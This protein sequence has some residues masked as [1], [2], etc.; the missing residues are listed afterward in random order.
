M[1]SRA[2]AIAASLLAASAP[3]A[4]EVPEGFEGRAILALAD[5]AMVASGY[6]DGRLGPRAADRLAVIP[7]GEGPPRAS[8]VDVSNSV[9]TWPNVL[10]LTPDQR[11]AIVTEP[12]AQ[13]PE[14]ASLFEE[15][16]RGRRISVIDV[17]DPAAPRVV[18]EIDAPGTPAAVDVHPSGELVAVTLPFQGE[19]ALYPF[20]DGRL[21]TPMVQDL[22]L[23]GVDDTFVPEFKW[24]PDGRFAA[25]TLGGADRVAFFR[26][27]EGRLEPWGEPLV[28]A[29]LPGKGAWTPDGRH[30]VVT[31]ITA[32]PDMAQVAYGR[33]ATLL[34][35]F[36]FD[37]TAEPDSPPRRADDRAPDPVSAGVQHARIAQLPAGLGYVENFAISPNGRH[38]VG[39]NM[40]AS[41]LP[42]GHPGRS[43]H[44]AL[45]LFRLD[46]ETGTIAPLDTVR[47]EGTILPQGIAFD[48]AGGHLVVTS[49][50]HDDRE[51]GSLSFWRL[52]GTEGGAAGL[53]P[54]G[55]PITVPR[56]VHLVEVLR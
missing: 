24:R 8:A 23:D 27:A 43:D 35:V 56:G 20:A 9:A 1:T 4:A 39:L 42:E 28:T 11:H 36:A 53:R 47:L 45:A 7:L 31:T 18:Q 2:L 3:A 17:S 15:I 44:S 14:E 50:Q 46:G 48:A 19:I 25:V 21:G 52:A 34:A 26:L 5:G 40:V 33:N 6:I 29:P 54:A 13:P 32:T 12:F 22:G 41:W 38:L 16:R 49:F 37:D 10:A 55:A 30:F 51:G